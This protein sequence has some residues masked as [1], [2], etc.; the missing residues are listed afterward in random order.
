[1]KGMVIGGIVGIVVAE[2][3]VFLFHLTP[4]VAMLTGIVCGFFGSFIGGIRRAGA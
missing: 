2:A 4:P 3:L 1:M